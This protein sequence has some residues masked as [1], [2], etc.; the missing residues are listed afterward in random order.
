MAYFPLKNSAVALVFEQK[1]SEKPL[2]LAGFSPILD[3]EKEGFEPLRL[4][5]KPYRKGVCAATSLL[6]PDFYPKR[7]SSFNGV[8]LLLFV[9][10]IVRFTLLYTATD[11]IANYMFIP[12]YNHLS[13]QSFLVIP[14]VPRS[15]M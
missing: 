11:A 15:S 2:Y 5:T 6:L 14:L 3:T 8:S 4:S 13:I 12:V 7:L 10:V 9:V 1:T